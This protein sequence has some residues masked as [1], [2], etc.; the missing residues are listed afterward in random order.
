M[1]ARQIKQRLQHAGVKTVFGIV[2]GQIPER[3]GI[4]LRPLAVR[5]KQVI[6]FGS[7]KTL[8]LGEQRRHGIRYCH[9][10]AS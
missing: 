9:N 3:Q 6:H 7:G 1:L 2:V 10:V 8:V 4:F 5:G